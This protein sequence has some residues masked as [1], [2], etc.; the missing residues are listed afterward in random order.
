MHENERK[1]TDYVKE[2]VKLSHLWFGYDVLKLQQ[3]R[4]LGPSEGAHVVVY[5]RSLGLGQ[6]EHEQAL[7]EAFLACGSSDGG[8]Q[9]PRMVRSDSSGHG[10]WRK[11]HTEALWSETRPPVTG[12]SRL[13]IALNFQCRGDWRIV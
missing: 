2:K 6:T 11:T 10:T 1:I 4:V 3:G 13:A 8:K 9:P 5:L 12:S 7:H